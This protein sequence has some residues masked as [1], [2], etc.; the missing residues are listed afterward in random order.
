MLISSRGG[1]VKKKKKRKADDPK[2]DDRD[3]DDDDDD[4]D[5]EENLPPILEGRG[6]SLFER[7]HLVLSLW[8]ILSF[9]DRKKQKRGERG[10]FFCP[11]FF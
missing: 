3:D 8:R 11:F 9:R 1:G 5:D 2:E 7:Y 10:R 4:D 6:R